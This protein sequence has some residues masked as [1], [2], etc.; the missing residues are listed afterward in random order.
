MRSL[1]ATLTTGAIVG[2]DHDQRVRKRT[3]AIERRN[4]A[5][6]LV[7]HMLEL[8][9]KCLHLAGIQL[10]LLGRERIPCG[11]V[12]RAGG[13]LCALREN[14]LGYLVLQNLIACL[15]P[16]HV[17]LSEILFQIC[18]RSMMRS[19]HGTG[20]P[21][22]HEGTVRSNGSLCRD[23]VNGAVGEIGRNVV[24]GFVQ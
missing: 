18:L 2:G 11:N 7:I 3:R 20:R 13:W 17:E 9:G 4:D 12:T 15:V 21:L 14:T 19:M 24:V 23:P 6:D 16:A 5:A 1:Q 8:G 10:L 22:H